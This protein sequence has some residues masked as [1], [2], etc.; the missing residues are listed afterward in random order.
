[1]AT[2][3]FCTIKVSD[4]SEIRIVRAMHLMPVR[5]CGLSAKAWVEKDPDLAKVSRYNVY[6]GLITRRTS[7]KSEIWSTHRSCR[8]SSDIENT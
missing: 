7:L 6:I 2:N 4:V 3:D 5:L 8:K 1:M